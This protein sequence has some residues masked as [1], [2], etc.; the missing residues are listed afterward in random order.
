MEHVIEIHGSVN[1]SEILKLFQKSENQVFN[2]IFIKSVNKI[3]M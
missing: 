3:K 1:A 2:N